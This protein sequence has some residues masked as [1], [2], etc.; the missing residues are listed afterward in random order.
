MDIR[1]LLTT[2]D[3]EN[4][5][6][7]LDTFKYTIDNIVA[8][9]FDDKQMFSPDDIKT[10]YYDEYKL[11]T[12]VCMDTSAIL[13]LEIN[14]LSNIKRFNEKSEIQDRY[15]TLKKIKDDLTEICLNYFDSN[16]LIWQAKYS[17]NFAINVYND[18][19]EK[20]THYFQ[21]IPCFTQTNEDNVS[22]VMYHTNDKMLIEKEYPRLSIRNFKAKNNATND[23]YRQYILLFKNAFKNDKKINDLPFEIFEVL[24]YCV[25]NLYFTDM[26]KQTTLKILDYIKNCGIKLSK[27]LDEQQY[28]F[29][30]K[31]KSLSSIYA[32][33]VIKRL[34]KIFSN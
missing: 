32:Q 31:Y 26:S 16:T 4:K 22:G 5:D 1:A 14:Q 7:I 10:Y 29:K 34:I 21:I 28:A 33:M 12:N 23:L 24:L 25:P 19:Q 9:Y 27:T 11:G 13:Y 20:F 8:E 30:S 18:D 15:L 17:I 6:D 2:F 3:V